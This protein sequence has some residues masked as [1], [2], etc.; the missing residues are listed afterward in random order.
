MFTEFALITVVVNVCLAVSS[1]M[2]S[3]NELLRI[4]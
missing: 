4:R 1:G 3:G 2:T